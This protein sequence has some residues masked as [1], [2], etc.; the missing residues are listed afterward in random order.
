MSYKA[1]ELTLDQTIANLD[2][3]LETIT[4]QQKLLADK[5]ES[6]RYQRQR[7]Y[8]EQARTDPDIEKRFSYVE[9]EQEKYLLKLVYC[10]ISSSKKPLSPQEV[11]DLLPGEKTEAVAYCLRRLINTAHI[12]VI[13]F[14]FSARTDS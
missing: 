11:H 3:E 2:L 14:Q 6:V 10:V 9:N 7:I 4:I 12:D 1:K 8:E 5:A 13:D